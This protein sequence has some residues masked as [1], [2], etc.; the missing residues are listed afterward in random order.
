[1]N[2]GP[3]ADMMGAY[4]VATLGWPLLAFGAVGAVVL[5]WRR[6]W[7]E[8]ALL[9]GPVLLFVGYFSTKTVF[10]ERNLS[11]VLP[12]FLI[13]GAVGVVAVAEWGA[14]MLRVPIWPIAMLVV[15]I[16]AVQP[17]RVTMPL[18]TMAFSGEGTKQRI[19]Y[20]DLLR[21]QHPAAIWR[22]TLLVNDGPLNELADHFKV[23]REAV[24]L[25]VTDFHDE[26]TN[27]CL[28]LLSDRFEV[29]SV[30]EFAG[31]FAAQPT[32]TLLTYHSAQERYYLVKGMR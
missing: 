6:R 28:R 20:D 10:F 1:M 4:F 23:R 8:L 15:A 13:L 16:L 5:A 29:K 19:A 32:S 22:E 24:L 26:W 17:G 7:A 11:H 9:A 18:V 25:R 3:V 12:L 21:R 27:Y 31:S 14:Q 2:G 30:G